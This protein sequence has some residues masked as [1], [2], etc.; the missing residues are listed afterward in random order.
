MDALL[1]ALNVEIDDHVVS[2][3]EGRGR[4]PRLMM[5]VVAQA[6]LVF[7]NELRWI[8]YAYCRLGHMFHY[9]SGHH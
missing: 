2:S 7:D 8:R 4:R 3:R 6:L 1:T 5:V 9:L